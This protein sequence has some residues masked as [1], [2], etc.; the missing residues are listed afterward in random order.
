MCAPF[1]LGLEFD[2]IAYYILSQVCLLHTNLSE[3]DVLSNFDKVDCNGTQLH[4]QIQKV[5]SYGV[6]L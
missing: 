3:A 4:A 6:Q 2:C 1:R 5:L